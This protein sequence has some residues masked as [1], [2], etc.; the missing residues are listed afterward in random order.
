MPL[1]RMLGFYIIA[2][3]IILASFGMYTRLPFLKEKLAHRLDKVQR[4]EGTWHISR[5]GSLVFDWEYIRR[6]P[7]IGWGLHNSARFALNPE[8]VG[9]PSRM[10]NGMSDFTV[11]LGIAGMLMWL[12]SVFRGVLILAKRNVPTTLLAML[13]LLLLLQGECFLGY[14]LFLGLMFLHRDVASPGKQHN[15]RRGQFPMPIRQLDDNSH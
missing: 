7:L 15:A 13:L 4:R 2:P 10:G 9:V 11:R 12:F 6:R 3:A 5:F 14:P 1:A 8:C